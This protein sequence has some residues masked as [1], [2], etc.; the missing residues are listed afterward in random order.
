ML[1][2]AIYFFFTEPEATKY[3]NLLGELFENYDAKV[4]PAKHAGEEPVIIYLDIAISKI[5]DL[6]RR[7]RRT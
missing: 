2:C 6:V 3:E 4:F 5:I 1:G 7:I